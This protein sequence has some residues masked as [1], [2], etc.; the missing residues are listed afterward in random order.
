MITK[1]NSFLQ[2]TKLLLVKN[3]GC[4]QERSRILVNGL[5]TFCILP[6][7]V[8]IWR[9]LQPDAPTKTIWEVMFLI[10]ILMPFINFFIISQAFY[11]LVPDIAMS[12]WFFPFDFRLVILPHD[13]A[14]ID[15]LGSP[16][17][18]PVNEGEAL[19]YLSYIWMGTSYVGLALSIWLTYKL[20]L[21][22]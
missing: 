1:V 9:R 14:F 12:L 4:I 16:L 3:V 11:F 20:G 18:G 5:I 22:N 6:V 21:R 10:S 2:F 13:N 15:L 7:G 19:I 8:W 17:I